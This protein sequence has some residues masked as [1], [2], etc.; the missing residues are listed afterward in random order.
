M[1][2]LQT[3]V[4]ILRTYLIVLERSSIHF[5]RNFISLVPLVGRLRE[6]NLKKKNYSLM[7]LVNR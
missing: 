6:A 1:Y 2:E 7:I 3:F 5:K 4:Y